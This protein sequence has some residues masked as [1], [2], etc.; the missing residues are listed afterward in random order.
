M[1]IAVPETHSP[2]IDEARA[3]I[4]KLRNPHNILQTSD[5]DALSVAHLIGLFRASKM[6]QRQWCAAVGLGITSLGMW[7]T[8]RRKPGQPWPA[9]AAA[10]GRPSYTKPAPSE[11]PHAAYCRLWRARKAQAQV[12]QP[13]ALEEVTHAA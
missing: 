12:Q 2:L 8:G 11:K 3:L 13:R 7:V 5:A 1:E 6:G 4:A 9:L 10:L